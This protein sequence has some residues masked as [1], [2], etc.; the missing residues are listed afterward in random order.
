MLFPFPRIEPRKP[1]TDAHKRLFFV[2]SVGV[3]AAAELDLEETASF[4]HHFHEYDPLPRPL[5]GLLAPACYA[6]GALFATGVNWLGWKMA[7]SPRWHK[8]WWVP[9]VTSIAGNL[10]GYSYTRAHQTAAKSRKPSVASRRTDGLNKKAPDFS[11]RFHPARPLGNTCAYA[12]FFAFRPF[13]AKV[14]RDL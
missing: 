7:R 8:T 13:N 11:G 1:V 5:A 12:F 10:V 3:Y 2:M 14:R 6:A 4:R 9:Q